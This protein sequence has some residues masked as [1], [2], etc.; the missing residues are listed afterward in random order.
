MEREKDGIPNRILLKRK[1]QHIGNAFKFCYFN[2]TI[3]STPK[4]FNLKP[5]RSKN[6]HIHSNNKMCN[7]KN[8]SWFQFLAFSILIWLNFDF[9]KASPDDSSTINKTNPDSEN[10]LNEQLFQFAQTFSVVNVHFSIYTISS[11]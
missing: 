2:Q 3:V 4:D 6:R 9:T 5:K 10:Q 11:K 1:K 8:F 7:A